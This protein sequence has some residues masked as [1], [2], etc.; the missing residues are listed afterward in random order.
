MIVK[1]CQLKELF[2]FIIS[3]FKKAVSVDEFLEVCETSNLSKYFTESNVKEFMADGFLAGFLSK[4][5]EKFMVSAQGKA[6]ANQLDKEDFKTAL[7][8]V[9]DMEGK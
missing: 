8:L 5:K 1:Q 4:S 9:L 3:K 2:Y 7:C 6:R